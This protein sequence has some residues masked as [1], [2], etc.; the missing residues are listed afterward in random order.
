MGAQIKNLGA[1]PQS[2]IPKNFNLGYRAP[3]AI[4]PTFRQGIGEVDLQRPTSVP[5]F[6]D[7][8]GIGT[9]RAA[10][11]QGTACLQVPAASYSK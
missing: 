2:T 8:A 1:R 6:N 5:V 7:P 3:I 4:V 11:F 9:D 10:Y